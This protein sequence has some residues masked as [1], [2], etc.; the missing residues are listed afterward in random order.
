ME[1]ENYEIGGEV[2][3]IPVPRSYKDCF[4]LAQSDMPGRKEDMET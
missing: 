2:V 4:I 1:Y 3:T